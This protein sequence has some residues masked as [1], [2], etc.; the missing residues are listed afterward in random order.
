MQDYSVEILDLSRR[1]L[2]QLPSDLPMYTRLRSLHCHHNRLTSLRGLPPTLEQ[3]YCHCNELTD[4]DDL[5]PGLFS[6]ICHHNRI[7]SLDRLPPAINI[8]YCYENRLTQ[9]DNLH[10]TQIKW[11]DCCENQIA[12]LDNLPDTVESLDCRNNPQEYEFE[13]TL[14]NI[15]AYCASRPFYLLK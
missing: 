13:P 9:L 4:L 14:E 6:L 15:R 3:L 8:V 5:P 2:S 12:R 1:G 10:H 11:L 7:T